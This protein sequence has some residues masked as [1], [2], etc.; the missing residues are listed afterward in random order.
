LQV[1]G[2]FRAL[3]DASLTFTPEGKP[4]LRVFCAEVARPDKDGQWPQQA[5]TYSL[6]CGGQED[7]LGAL[8]EQIT[9]GARFVAL[10]RATWREYD[11]RDGQRRG[12]YEL[13]A[14]SVT[15]EAAAPAAVGQDGAD[16]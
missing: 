5:P 14:D 8:A 12:S 1:A 16:W 6:S 4:R 15:P 10:G 2:R 7:R 9:K 13:W 3:S 11:G